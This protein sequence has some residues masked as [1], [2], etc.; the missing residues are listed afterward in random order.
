MNNKHSK[1]YRKSAEEY[2]RS[3][4]Y[5]LTEAVTLVKKTANTKFNAGIEVHFNLGIN[6]GQSSQ[7][8]KGTV[9]LPHGTGKKVKVAVFCSP[10]NEIAVKEAG[11]GLVGGEELIKEI[12]KTEK[13]DFDVAVATPEMMRQL[14][15]IAKILGT[16]GLMPSPKND[17]VSKDPAKTVAELMKGKVTF[18]SDNTGQVH[19]LAGKA[20]FEDKVLQENITAIIDAVKGVKPA[21]AKGTYL[22]AITIASSMGPGIKLA[23]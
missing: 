6:P 18:K 17:T 19:L 1:R 21:D 4:A 16:R 2:D 15:Q 8:V 22:K 5:P 3:K 14:A 10:D 20:S 11:A 7:T 9:A 13:T 23:I 12:K